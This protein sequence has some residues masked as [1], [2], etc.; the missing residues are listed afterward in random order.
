VRALWR[1]GHAEAAQAFAA[2]ALARDDRRRVALRAQLEALRAGRPLEAGAADA[3][4]TD[5]DVEPDLELVSALVERHRY[6]E[7]RW[8]LRAAG[9]DA[10]DPRGGRLGALLDEALAPF[11]D[12]ADP[13]FAAVLRLLAAGQ[14]PSALRALEEVARQSAAPA[15]WLGRRI[16]ALEALVRGGWREG[17]TPEPPVAPVAPVTRETVLA[18]LRARD[19][20]GALEA[21]RGAD[22]PELAAVL[23]RL[24]DAT[25]RVFSDPDGDGL[26]PE[27]VPMQGH[28]LCEFQIRMGVL[29]EAE[30]GYRAILRRAPADET[31]RARLSDVVALRRALGEEP[32]PVPRRRASM[33]QLK[34]NAPRATGGWASGSAARRYARFD[35]VEGEE[36][37]DVFLP[38]QEAELLLKLGKAEQALQVYRVLAIQH[39]NQQAYRKRIAEIEAL[40]AQRMTSAAAEATRKHDLSELQRRAVPTKHVRLPE[41]T[42]PGADGEPEEQPTLIDEAPDLGLDRDE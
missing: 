15:E 34:K 35:E 26:E 16:G 22:A 40:I 25:E 20:P 29:H 28:R 23:Q 12:D 19:L 27:T 6:A 21:A 10:E 37:T 42:P 7:A 4:A 41:A 8:L 39:P 32:E 3:G 30:R 1:R 17:A 5:L 13:A 9:L 11:P 2:A 33:D 18:R 24:V 31:A 38:A 36:S 14:A